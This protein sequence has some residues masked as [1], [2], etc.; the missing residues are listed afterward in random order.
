MTER[1]RRDK[2][3][4]EFGVDGGSREESGVDFCSHLKLKGKGIGLAFVYARFVFGFI[5]FWV[6]W[7]GIWVFGEPGWLR[8]GLVGQVQERKWWLAWWFSRVFN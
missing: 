2:E 4:I 7:F 1:R 3:D 5:E 8:L 6:G